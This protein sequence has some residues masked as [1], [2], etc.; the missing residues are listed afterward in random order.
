LISGHESEESPEGYQD[1]SLET[2]EVAYQEAVQSLG[3]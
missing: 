1:L 2:V 3:L